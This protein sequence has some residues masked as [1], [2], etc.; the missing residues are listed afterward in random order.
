M[1]RD[2]VRSTTRWPQP[3][4]YSSHF[5]KLHQIK[6][7]YH[8]KVKEIRCMEQLCS[9]IKVNSMI[10]HA[11]ILTTL[12]KKKK[13]ASRCFPAFSSTNLM[14]SLLSP[15]MTQP[16]RF[17]ALPQRYL[18]IVPKLSSTRPLCIYSSEHLFNFLA[19]SIYSSKK[20][21]PPP[22]WV[23]LLEGGGGVYL[24]VTLSNNFVSKAVFIRERRLID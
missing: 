19:G 10:A 17:H 20:T 24:R 18:D 22:A 8:S 13:K 6:V 16:T 7:I 9:F 3:K 15:H 14:F 4:K 11:Y 12:E 1:R 23:R 21:P 5:V 2:L